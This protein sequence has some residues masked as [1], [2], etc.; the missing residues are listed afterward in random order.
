[1]TSKSA[2]TVHTALERMREA[3][4]LRMDG[5]KQVDI[6]AQ[7]GVNQSTV[8]RYLAQ[9]RAE[10]V[11]ET[12]GLAATLR[13]R[14]AEGVRAAIEAAWQIVDACLEAE[15]PVVKAKGAAAVGQVFKGEE[16]LARL[17][18]LDAPIRVEG[19]FTPMTPEEAQA[20][21]DEA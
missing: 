8:A 12:Q 13:R 16:R 5:M 9:A 4:R 17:Y 7:L 6:A 21:L 11:E 20:I 18:G 3:H 10:L 14:E 15:D 19:S 2:P 1:M